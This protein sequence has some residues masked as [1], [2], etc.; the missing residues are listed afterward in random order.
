MKKILL[1]ILLLSFSS[2]ALAK[3]ELFVPKKSSVSPDSV[4]VTSY[5][6]GQ[7]KKCEEMGII[8]S[9]AFWGGLS[10]KKGMLK[11]MRKHV[12]KVGGTDILLKD[13]GHGDYSGSN[14]GNGVVFY[15]PK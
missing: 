9:R 7:F 1:T 15:C 2:T 10:T 6:R 3:V 11:R 8:H 4:K 12:G 13:T 5:D 14:V